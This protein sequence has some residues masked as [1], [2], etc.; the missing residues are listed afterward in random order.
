MAGWLAPLDEVSDPVFASRTM[1]EGFAIDPVEGL[2]TAPCDGIVAAL[3]PT[4]HS[5]TIE[6]ADGAMILI[7]IGLDTVTLDGEGFD[8]LVGA[9]TSVRAGDP[10]IR[11]DMDRVAHAA[12][13]LMTPVLAIGENDRIRVPALGRLITRGEAIA[14]ISGAG[15]RARMVDAEVTRSVIV[16][17]PHGI[18]ARPAARIVDAVKPY[19]AQVE[20]RLADR[21]ASA[22][23]MIGLLKL[24]A[25][26]GDDVTIAAEGADADAAADAVATLILSGMGET[27]AGPVVSAGPAPVTDGPRLRGVAAA[28]GLAIGT[29]AQFG[30]AEI[31]VPEE[32]RGVAQERAALAQALETVR[33]ALGSAIAG[34]AAGIAQA[35]QSLLG[36]PELCDSAERQIAAGRSAAYAWRS[37]IRESAAT[38]TATGDPLMMERVA[39]LTDLERQVVSVLTGAANTAQDLPANAILVA[40]D[41]L[42][43][44]FQALDKSRLAGVALAAGGPTSHV[45]VLAAS[46]GVPMLVALGPAVRR[47]AD[48]SALILDVQAG[49]LDTAPDAE[50]LD[51]AEHRLAARRAARTDARR[52]A[53]EEARTAD[54]IRVEVFA[55]LGSVEDAARAVAEGAEGCGLLRSEFLFLG[56]E[57]APDEDEQAGIY[58]A[59]AAALGDRPLIVRTFDIGGDKPVPYLPMAAEENP[60]LGMRG[61]RLNLLR[62]D[63]LDTQLRAVLRGVPARQRR[64]MVPM[65][66]EPSELRQVRDRLRAAETTLGIT[67]PTALGVMVETPAAALLADHIAAEADFLSI[68]SNDLTQYALACD[69]GNAA[70]A[71][72]VDALHPAV[73][74]LIASAAHGAAAHGRWLGVCGGIASDPDAAPLLIG[75]GA[76]ELSVA[77]GQIA[78]V[79]ACIR[80][81][82]L[83][84]CRRLAEQAL[85]CADTAEVLALLAA[86]A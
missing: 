61:V 6:A 1:G 57:R 55:N 74:R 52:S 49:E 18:H 73:L 34:P 13:S 79:K 66:I 45:A 9:G 43:S 70:T 56:R 35:H 86:D 46:A 77:P 82:D 17:M 16:P 71:A 67:E 31:T 30:R 41:L 5:V 50:A 39:D 19:H 10:L 12:R 65:I 40:D 2:V 83:P 8:L 21:R 20:L 62:P 14:E 47:I 32:G 33:S 48:G 75:L 27:H 78:T 22:R 84:S 81:L 85:G 15:A 60:A 54:G 38:L 59:I 80:T 4:R 44:E 58:A 25:R 29:S 63:L 68:G 24:A 11:F 36:D 64:I 7:H 28:P 72:R 26:H 51:K 37:V 69:R 53:G 23:S 76:T 3:A 42:P